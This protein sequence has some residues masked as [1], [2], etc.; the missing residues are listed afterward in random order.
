MRSYLFPIASGLFL[1]SLFDERFWFRVSWRTHFLERED[2]IACG[3]G[4]GGDSGDGWKLG[5]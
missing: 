2:S 4:G 1:M 5:L 3:V